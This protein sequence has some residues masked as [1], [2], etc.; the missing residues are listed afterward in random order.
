[1]R[2]RSIIRPPMMRY[3]ARANELPPALDSW[4]KSERGRNCYHVVGVKAGRVGIGGGR[5]YVL[6]LERFPADKIPDDADVHL[7]KWSARGK[8]RT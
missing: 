3:H 5:I 6:R 8:K 2:Q 7:I 4:L 1:M